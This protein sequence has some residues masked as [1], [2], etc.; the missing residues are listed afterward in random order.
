MEFDEADRIGLCELLVPLSLDEGETLFREGDAAD[1]LYLVG[2]GR[3]RIESAGCGELGLLSDGSSLGA[4]SLMMI[5]SRKASAWAESPCDLLVLSRADFL[6]LAEDA[7]R[8]ACRLAQ[9]VV[10]E[11]VAGLRPQ[12]ARVEREFSAREGLASA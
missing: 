9:A 6:R 12:L 3:I 11:L 10:A 1:A 7:P 8:T 4:L 5:G 2:R